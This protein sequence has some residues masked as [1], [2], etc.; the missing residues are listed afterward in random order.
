[1][2]QQIFFITGVNGIGKSTLVFYLKSIFDSAN[3]K[4]HDFDERGVPNN[5]DKNWRQSETLHWAQ[6]GK[7]NLKEGIST[8]VCGFMKSSEIQDAIKQLAINV[9]VCVLDANPEIILSRISGRYTTPESLIELKR[10][11]GKT[12]EKFAA[13]NVWISSKF[14][15]EA[16]KNNYH[17][18]DTS[19]FAPKDVAKNVQKWILTPCKNH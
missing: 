4:I 3:F 13:D 11:T 7:E 6:L 14:R 1:M 9:Q 18:L 2:Q 5:A 12:P 17:L 8:I 15:E 19:K 10:T 16:K